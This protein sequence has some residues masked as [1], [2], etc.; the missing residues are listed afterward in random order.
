M[1]YL[2]G[3]TENPTIEE[4][5]KGAEEKVVVE[6]KVMVASGEIVATKKMLMSGDIPKGTDPVRAR[7]YCIP[8]HPAPVT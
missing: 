3:V 8:F 6:P 2:V 4:G 7:V 5:Q 1:L